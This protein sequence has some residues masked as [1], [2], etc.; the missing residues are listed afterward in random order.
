MFPLFSELS[1]S[2]SLF[3]YCTGNNICNQ[4]PESY[5]TSFVCRVYPVGK[6]DYSSF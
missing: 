6:E 2:Y 3:N 5:N 4:C 1:N